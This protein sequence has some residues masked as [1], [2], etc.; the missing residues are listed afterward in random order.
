LQKDILGIASPFLP[1]FFPYG[2]ELVDGLSGAR[3]IGRRGKIG[4][5][6]KSHPLGRLTGKNMINHGRRS[7]MLRAVLATGL[8]RCFQTVFGPFPV[9]RGN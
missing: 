2:G 9:G 5:V 6:G 4:Q 3:E 7:W 1:W 8:C